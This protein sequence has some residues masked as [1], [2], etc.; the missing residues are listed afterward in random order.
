MKI[1]RKGLHRASAAL[2]FF[3]LCQRGLGQ[4]A[5]GNKAAQYIN[6]LMHRDS[7][8]GAAVAV[9]RNG[10]PVYRQ[11]FGTANLEL[12]KKTDSR[13][14]F[15]I[16]SVSKQFTAAAIMLLYQEGRLRTDDRITQYFPGAPAD[17]NGIT[18]DNLL[19]H[20]SGL[21][22]YEDVA[23][24]AEKA[25][26]DSPHTEVANSVLHSLFGQKLRFAPGTRSEYCNSNYFLL[27]MIIEKVTDSSYETFLNSRILRPLD[28]RQTRIN[29]MYHIVPGRVDGYTTLNGALVNADRLGMDWFFAE[30]NIICSLDDLT[31]WVQVPD[32]TLL[33]PETYRRMLSAE[34]LTGGNPGKFGYGWF[35]DDDP[36]ITY[37]SGHTPG[38]SAFVYRNAT[39]KTAIVL[40]FNQDGVAT[41][42]LLEAAKTIDGYY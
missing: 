30:G 16:A 29:E 38:F 34:K 31:K 17:W 33:R 7:I 2:L 36:A 5:D 4:S 24:F 21:M 19:A 18:I 10:K 11:F 20:S 41:P 8:P 15:Q 13:S 35:V 42:Q 9:I 23:G 25:Y 14:I 12:D 3:C 26:L 1:F 37:H 40:L 32:G 6:S 39:K 28:M 22:N 27:G